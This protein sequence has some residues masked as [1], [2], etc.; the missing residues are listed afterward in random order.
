MKN[1]LKVTM[2]W[3]AAAIFLFALAINVKV[4]LDDPF[5]MVSDEAV[6]QTTSQPS[7]AISCPGGSCTFKKMMGTSVLWECT[8]CCQEQD[9]AK[10]DV[11]GCG[12]EPR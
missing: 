2:T 5:V 4:T 6:A 1:K 12:C 7:T 9:K 8:A 11:Y 10:C 3:L